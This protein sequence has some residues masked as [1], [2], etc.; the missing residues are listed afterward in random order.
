MWY[1][2]ATQSL[3]DEAERFSNSVKQAQ[4]NERIAGYIAIAA[5]AKAKREV[6][7]IEQIKR[8]SYDGRNL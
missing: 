7:L 4:L 2:N 6:A 5:I 8:E 1:G 3:K